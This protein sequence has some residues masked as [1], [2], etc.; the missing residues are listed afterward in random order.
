MESPDS[1]H[2]GFLGPIGDF[3]ALGGSEPLPGLRDVDL[4]P[5]ASHAIM[6][7]PPA[8]GPADHWHDAGVAIPKLRG[9]LLLTRLEPQ[10][11][12]VSLSHTSSCVWTLPELR[13]EGPLSLAH[14]DVAP[15]DS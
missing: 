9:C 12:P 13:L 6:A 4:G 8:D 2:Q 7:P 5:R 11:L 15:P 10:G 3:G 14:V 1:I